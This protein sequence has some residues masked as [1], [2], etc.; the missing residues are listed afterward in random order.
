MNLWTFC[1]FVRRLYRELSP[2][3][4]RNLWQL[5]IAR[6]EPALRRYH[7]ARKDQPLVPP[8]LFLSLTTAC[9]LRCHGCWVMPEAGGEHL[10]PEVAHSII[11]S[12]KRHGLF[13]YTLLGG[14]PLLYP[15]LWE[16]LERHR[17]CYFQV[18]T[19]GLN[20]S[21]GVARRW[22]KLANVTPLVSL[23]G[24][25]PI[26]DARRGAGTFAR[27]MDALSHLRAEKLFFGVAT[28]ISRKNIHDV[29]TDV[30]VDQI[31]HMGGMYLWYYIHRPMGRADAVEWCLRSDEILSVRRALLRLRRHHPILIIDTYWDAEGRAVC[32]AAWGLGYHIGAGGSLEPCPPLSVGCEVLTNSCDPVVTISQSRFLREFAQFVHSRTR[33]CVIL[34][35]PQELSQFIREVGAQDFSGGRLLDLLAKLP[36]LPSH[37]QAGAEIPEGSFLYRFFKRRLFFGL[38][39]YG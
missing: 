21:P 9:N 39:G 18:I 22:G 27:V 38:G 1:R 28:T 14:E 33:G 10:P 8:F 4:R 34:E 26:N 15:A 37:H 7:K 35:Y 20:I 3:V 25:E 17:D 13:F 2:E 30:Y 36:Q 5:W 19:N 24:F 16:I 23:D 12:G 31:I 32:P 11:Q 29:L 6:V